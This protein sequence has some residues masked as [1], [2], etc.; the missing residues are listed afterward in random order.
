[1]GQV[2]ISRCRYLPASLAFVLRIRH[3]VKV[4]TTAI[5]FLGHAIFNINLCFLLLFRVVLYGFQIWSLTL[6]VFESRVLG[7]IFGPRRAR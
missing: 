4:I 6:R 2:G 3:I 7:K 1:M 5:P